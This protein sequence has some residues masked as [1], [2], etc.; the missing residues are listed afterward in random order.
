MPESHLIPTF[1]LKGNRIA[2][3]IKEQQAQASWSAA[4]RYLWEGGKIVAA[5]EAYT[6]ARYCVTEAQA[7]GDNIR[8]SGKDVGRGS[9]ET[10]DYVRGEFDRFSQ[11]TGRSIV[12][13]T[14]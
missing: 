12:D 6:T 2:F 5:N 1:N 10:T 7:C 11:E 9:Q 8:R 13:W 3:E 14:Y 4:G